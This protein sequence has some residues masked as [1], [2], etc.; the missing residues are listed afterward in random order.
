MLLTTT[1]VCACGLHEYWTFIRR[2]SS[3]DPDEYKQYDSN[4]AYFAWQKRRMDDENIPWCS[5]A[6]GRLRTRWLGGSVLYPVKG[7]PWL[8]MQRLFV[9]VAQVLI[10][11]ALSIQF[12]QSDLD[13]CPAECENSTVLTHTAAENLTTTAMLSGKTSWV[14]ARVECQCK[15]AECECLPNGLK[16]SL[17]TAVIALPIIGLLNVSFGLLRKPLAHDLRTKSGEQWEYLQR[18]HNVSTVQQDQADEERRS[19]CCQS[20]LRAQSSCVSCVSIQVHWCR[21]HCCCGRN[22]SNTQFL[23]KKQVVHMQQ[24][25]TEAND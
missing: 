10:S 25:K 9:I 16:A 18:Q 23:P 3:D 5:R 14:S 24:C 1:I 2:A 19:S 21:Q 17:L 8:R 7:D 22:D 12:Y 13:A 11:M 15:T 20:L 6:P 4:V